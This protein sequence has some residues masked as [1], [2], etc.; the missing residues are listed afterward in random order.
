VGAPFPT[1]QVYVRTLSRRVA[2]RPSTECDSAQATINR[3]RHRDVA[4]NEDTTLKYKLTPRDLFNPPP[5]AR[6]FGNNYAL[7][8][9]REQID[10]CYGDDTHR[11][12]RLFNHIV[13]VIQEHEDLIGV[14]S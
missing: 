3:S 2:A 10:D 5:Q 4:R 9:I 1:S 11:V 6:D 14:K 7:S 13:D 8:H 12:H